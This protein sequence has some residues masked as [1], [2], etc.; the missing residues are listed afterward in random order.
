MRFALALSVALLVLV[1]VGCDRTA[2][3]GGVQG[4]PEGAD[5]NAAMD[6]SRDALRRTHD[7]SGEGRACQVDRECDPPLRCLDMVCDWPV[8][9]TGERDGSTPIA[10]LRG[11]LGEAAYALE[12]ADE[13]GEQARGLMFRRT[14]VADYGM[15]FVFPDERP[16][17]FWMRNTLIPLDL[18]FIRADGTLD[19]MSENAQP[20]DE[21]GEPSD[22]PARYALELNAGEA[23]RLG[24]EPGVR[25]EFLNL[26]AA[27]EPWAP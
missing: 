8:A 2:D 19:S 25:V 18:L 23:A 26:P 20:L 7:V 1:G 5:A 3:A 4:T 6:S 16:R 21:R 9:M 27:Y 11:S 13:S 10:V 14:M 15:L 17:R 12:I 22:G 24:L